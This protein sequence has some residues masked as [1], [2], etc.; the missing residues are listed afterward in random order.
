[1]KERKIK[2]EK[3]GVNECVIIGSDWIAP[4]DTDSRWTPKIYDI[5]SGD[6]NEARWKSESLQGEEGRHRGN[7]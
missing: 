2:N 7:K 5:F 6:V 4:M 3:K 1:M